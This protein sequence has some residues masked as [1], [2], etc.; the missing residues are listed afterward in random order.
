MSDKN[1]PKWRNMVGVGFELVD[2]R[3]WYA[4][5]IWGTEANENPLFERMSELID[6]ISLLMRGRA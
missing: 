6:K 3:K 2:A 4:R 1:D 5:A